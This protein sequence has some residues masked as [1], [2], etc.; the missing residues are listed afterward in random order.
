MSFG[1]KNGMRGYSAIE[2]KSELKIYNWQIEY[3]HF[4]M[5]NKMKCFD[6]DISSHYCAISITINVLF[7][8]DELMY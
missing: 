7:G 8:V 4:K 5:T 3:I 1:I 6:D 2:D